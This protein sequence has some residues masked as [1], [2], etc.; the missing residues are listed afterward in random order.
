MSTTLDV[1]PRLNS[2]LLKTKEGLASGI[3]TA[4]LPEKVLQ[5]GEG[6][7]LRGFVDWMIDGMNQKGLFSGRVVVVQPL[8]QGLV[9][10]LN[11]QD[12][13]YTLL[14][15][16]VQNG[17]VVEKQQIITSA[18]R[19]IDPYADFESYLQCAHNPELRWIVSN[20]T[21]A[22]IAYNPDDKATDCPPSSYPGKLTRFLMERYKAF[23]GDPA[24]GFVIL[25]CELIDRNGDNLKKTVLRTAANWR[26]N[27]ELVEWVA[28][29]NTFTN[30]LVDRIVTGFPREEAEA[31]WKKA[32]YHDDLFDCAEV[33]HLWVIE[34]PERIAR[35][36]P[37]N[38]A[39]FNV[40]WTNDI[41]PYRE[42]KV[43]IL[44]GAHTSSVL[45]AFLAG[46]NYVGE[47]MNDEL[48]GGFIRKAIR[49]EVIPTLSLPKDEVEQ[50]ANAVF[51]RF[52][53]P[54]IKHALLSISLNSVSKYKAR[55]LPS[56]EQYLKMNGSV[57][58]RLAF[59]L[60]ALIVF[61]RGT[62]IRGTSLIGHRDGEE[63]PI[64]DDMPVL[65]TFSELWSHCDGSSASL[66]TVTNKV[67]ERSE[68]WG[69]D[70]T[71]FDGLAVAV[72][73]FVTSILKDGMPA[74]LTQ[75]G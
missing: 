47:M 44:N 49:E 4:N 65:T 30:T 50:F 3:A 8:S 2:G 69:E 28:K 45:A 25:P 60:A 22:G 43:R 24:K 40:L 46:K 19:G 53:N 58:R 10:K 72:S 26:L 15:R 61:Y 57:P 7:F 17:K 31:L 32:G 35:E 21:E 41:T 18:S 20:T 55:V 51:E 37:L 63:Y 54:F 67:L 70:L 52:S 64:T 16:G 13:L 34:A 11:E 73:G 5:F 42:R 62:E 36:F 33:F 48:T 71:Q 56:L 66:A 12:G 27:P 74:A 68:W 23:G 6:N 59:G 14:L 38:E 9:P 39:G 75:L 1:L 29:A